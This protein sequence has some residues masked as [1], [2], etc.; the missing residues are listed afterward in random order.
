MHK[1]THN[2]MHIL[3]NWM[4]LQL[5]MMKKNELFLQEFEEGPLNFKPTYKFDRKSDTYDTR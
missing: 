3:M 4:F 1:R 5:I 2:N